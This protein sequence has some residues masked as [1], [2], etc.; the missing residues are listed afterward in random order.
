MRS[1]FAASIMILA[2]A[3][4]AGAQEGQS[5]R[6]TGEV[7]QR[8]YEVGAFDAVAL[9]GSHDVVVSV[10]GA[11]S[12][13]AEGDAETLEQLEVRVEDG[14]LTIGNRDRRRLWVSFGRNRR[15]AT[16]Y[17]TVPSLRAASVAGSGD[18]RVDRAEAGSFDASLAGSG[19]LQIDSLRAGRA[20]FSVAGSGNIRAAGAA[21]SS[22]VS[23]AGSGDVDLSG[24]ETRTANVS[25]MG[26]G[27]VRL[28]ATEAADVSI[29]GSGDVEVAGGA[30]CSVSKHGSGDVRCA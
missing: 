28:R 15:P 8:N 11:P 1:L 26:S 23:I 6:G 3:C 16:V 27:D 17:V 20:E 12:V 2:A 5:A 7:V 18:M 19:D 13:R 21:Q 4:S 25:V 30:R 22:D 14:E 10:G 29:M 24:L 9:A